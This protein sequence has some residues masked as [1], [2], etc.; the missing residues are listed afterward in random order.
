MK[1]EIFKNRTVFKEGNA[2]T[3]N[4]NNVEIIEFKFPEELNGYEKYIEIETVDGKF[5]DNI[6]N[7]TYTLAR[8]ITKHNNVKTQ[9]VLKD[10]EKD[11]V[12]K[13]N[14]FILRFNNSINASEQLEE[15]KRG[16]LDI[17]ELELTEIKKEYEELE[18]RV[19]TL[20]NKKI[21]SE[22]IVTSAELTE[23][24]ADNVKKIYI[25]GSLIIENEDYIIEDNIIRFNFTVPSRNKNNIGKGGN[26]KCQNLLF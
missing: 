15:E 17:I 2:G 9:I 1:I 24:K 5:I 4:E 18:N 13:S 14:T 6:E 8:N 25:E 3:I 23:I 16:L 21:L 22:L 26:I 10:L 12:F 7:N 20:E 19:I 11:I